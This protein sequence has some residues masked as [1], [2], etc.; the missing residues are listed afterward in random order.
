MS[1]FVSK[2]ELADFGRHPAVVVDKRNDAGVQRALGALIHAAD[3]FRVRL[4]LLAYAAGGATGASDPRQACIE[5]NKSSVKCTPKFVPAMN[6][7]QTVTQEERKCL[8]VL[9]YFIACFDQILTEDCL[10][11]W[12][13]ISN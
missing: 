12:K 3:G 13:P 7:N 1:N 2:R 9:S 11:V 4:V 5:I 10:G 6:V 8:K